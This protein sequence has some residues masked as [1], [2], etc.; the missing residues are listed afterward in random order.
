MTIQ[1]NAQFHN[2][3]NCIRYESTSTSSSFLIGTY[4]LSRPT[5]TV[6]L[7]GLVY[8]NANVFIKIRSSWPPSTQVLPLQGLPVT[9]AKR[10]YKISPSPDTKSFQTLVSARTRI[11][12]S[13]HFR[14]IKLRSVHTVLLRS[15]SLLFC[16]CKNCDHTLY[17][18]RSFCCL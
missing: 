1:A 9:Q 11:M 2:T 16:V 14:Q 5:P 7:R 10:L 13:D 17:A 8:A 6:F 4:R 3:T 18:F 15:V 12:P